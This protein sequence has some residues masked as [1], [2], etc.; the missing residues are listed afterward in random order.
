MRTR[1]VLRR[2]AAA[3]AL[4]LAAACYPASAANGD[5]VE[6][7]DKLPYTGVTSQCAMGA[8]QARAFEE[9][10]RDCMLESESLES[11]GMDYPSF[12]RVALFDAGSGIPAM[13]V[14]EG[15][16]YGSVE[17][18]AYVP[19]VRRVYQWDGRRAVVGM[20]VGAMFRN[21]YGY[22]EVSDVFLFGGAI[23]LTLGFWGESDT[24]VYYVYPC[25]G[26]TISTEPAHRYGEYAYGA[27]Y[28][29]DDEADFDP[30]EL[31]RQEE[32]EE[33]DFS[34]LSEDKW[35]VNEWDM[36]SIYTKD[37]EFL[38]ERDPNC[39]AGMRKSVLGCGNSWHQDVD[40]EY[41]GIWDEAAP[42]ADALALYAASAPA[43][44]EPEEREPSEDA[45]PEDGRTA[46]PDADE[47]EE[48]EKERDE[49][50]DEE[51]EERAPEREERSLSTGMLVA[52]AAGAVVVIGAAAAVVAA[53][54]K[55]R[56][57]SPAS[58]AENRQSAASPAPDAE[59]RQPAAPAGRIYCTACGAPNRVDGSFCTSCGKPLHKG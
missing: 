14:L 37:G 35:S 45:R 15:R 23:V 57:A 48:R 18:P 53:G 38:R 44:A 32:L 9:V 41:Y 10:L 17:Y 25:S 27:Y 56:V 42:T 5:Y 33:L 2:F 51:P 21:E 20:D 31:L 4:V 11:Y 24:G 1:S 46:G 8:E 58:A 19:Q 13:L 47:P 40:Y 6:A 29:Y 28:Y 22:S 50:R 26:G 39:P 43:A 7:L 12:C 3:F 52:I 59:N 30:N 55:R 34:T 49:G 36:S 54:K 16:D